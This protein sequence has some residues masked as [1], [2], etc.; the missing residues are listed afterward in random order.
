MALKFDK[1]KWDIDLGDKIEPE[2]PLAGRKSVSILLGAGFSAPMGY[3]IGNDMNNGL[4]NFDESSLDFAPCGT[5]ASSTDGTK[6]K[7]QM[8][9]VLNIWNALIEEPN[10]LPHTLKLGLTSNVI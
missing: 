7:F 9:G 5:L 4:L 8:D 10:N 1:M 6:P 2:L 3:P